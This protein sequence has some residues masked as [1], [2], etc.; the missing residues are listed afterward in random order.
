[1][2]P[3]LAAFSDHVWHVGG[4][5]TGHLT[6]LLINQ[7]WFGQAAALAEVF[8]LGARAGVSPERL[9]AALAESPADSAFVRNDLPHVLDGDY[10]PAF[11]LSRIVKELDSVDPRQ[12][13]RVRRG[14]WRAAWP[15]LTGTP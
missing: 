1:M 15:S 13:Q 5:G 9:L 12:P 14:R 11:E 6:K 2:R 8:L 3:L 7:L 10:M 4:H